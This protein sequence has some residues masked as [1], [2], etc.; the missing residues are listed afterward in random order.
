MTQWRSR[1]L[2]TSLSATALLTPVMGHAAS[3][4][5][6]PGIADAPSASAAALLPQS[7]G[8]EGGGEGGEGGEGGGEGGEGGEGGGERAIDPDRVARDPVAWLT[9]LDVIRAHYLAGIAAYKAGDHAAAAEMFVHPIGEI[10]TAMDSLFAARDV[11]PF[12]DEMTATGDAAFAGA[13]I[14]QVEPAAQAVLQAVSAA[15]SHAPEDDR[16]AAYIQAQVIAD[17]IDRAALMYSRALS[18]PDGEAYLDGFGYY[19]AAA[20]RA[21]E[22]GDRIAEADAGLRETI[23]AALERLAAAYPSAERPDSLDADAGAL[24][25]AASRVALASGGL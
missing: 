16:S 9:A 3:A 6:A 4:A 1:R 25:A 5:D 14:E 8:G 7:H 22:A 17:M 20:A 24:L 15:E 23:D 19:R 11:T 21:A 13:D 10:Y 12:R 2:W 18:D